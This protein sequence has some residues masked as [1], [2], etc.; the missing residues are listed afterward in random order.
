MSREAQ[1][2]R[3]KQAEIILG[4][5]EMEIAI[6]SV[7]ASSIPTCCSDAHQSRRMWVM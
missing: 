1:A 2:G 7:K 5:A 3:E 6:R 4:H